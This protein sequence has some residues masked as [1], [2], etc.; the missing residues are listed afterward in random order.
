[1]R[2]PA[3]VSSNRQ[4]S[5]S[6]TSGPGKPNIRRLPTIASRVMAASRV[7]EVGPAGAGEARE[8]RP[9]RPR[10]RGERLPPLDA[11]ANA[12][13]SAQEVDGQLP[14]LELV[15]R[16]APAKAAGG[17]APRVHDQRQIGRER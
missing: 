4:R 9:P 11:A 14:G 1:M 13:A 3:W 5:A 2:P 16:P 7:Q 12:V 15:G 6:V 10:E 8:G 17:L